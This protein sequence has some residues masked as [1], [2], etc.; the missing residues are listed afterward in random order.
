MKQ[1]E[2]SKRA[3]IVVRADVVDK[4]NEISAEIG[5]GEPFTVPLSRTG[6]PP[7]QAALC[8]WQFLPEQ[9]AFFKDRRDNLP[10]AIRDKVAIFMLSSL[11]PAEATPTLDEI[12]AGLDLKRIEAAP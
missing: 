9:I 7:M 5:G 2:W 3:I 6:Q 12:L 8:N 10:P 4:A 1:T 11:D